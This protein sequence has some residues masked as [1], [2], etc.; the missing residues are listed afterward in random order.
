MLVK[1]LIE[2]LQKYEGEMEVLTSDFC[3]TDACQFFAV[4]DVDLRVVQR[5]YDEGYL[6]EDIGC[7]EKSLTEVVA[8]FPYKEEKENIKTLKKFKS[9]K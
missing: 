5:K 7:S 1:E 8:L 9:K 4:G 3:K 2:K 6:E